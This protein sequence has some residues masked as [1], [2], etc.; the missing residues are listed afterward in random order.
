MIF[1][2]FLRW[3]YYEVPLAIIHIWRNFLSFSFDFFGVRY[4]LKTLFKP[5]HLVVVR[6][7][8]ESLI[9][10]FFLNLA[11]RFIA[12]LVGMGMRL[13]TIAMGL[14]S[15]LSFFFLGIAIELF[16]LALPFLLVYSFLQGVYFNW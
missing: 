10:K 1:F 11:S 4:H 14:L 6:F 13:F 3:H 5:W 2:E 16:W 8:E 15:A 9:K 7:D 12:S